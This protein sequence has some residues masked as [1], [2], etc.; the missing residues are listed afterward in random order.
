MKMHILSSRT[1]VCDD[2]FKREHSV[3]ATNDFDPYGFDGE[4]LEVG[5]VSKCG[6]R[7]Q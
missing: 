6:I 3:R 7:P 1:S 5:A 2:K 4:K